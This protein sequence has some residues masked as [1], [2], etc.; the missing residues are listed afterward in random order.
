MFCQVLTGKQPF[1][2]MRPPELAY[3]V[4]SG[5]RPDKPADAEAIGISKSLWELIQKC[6]FGDKTRRPQIQEVVAGVGNAADNWH[7]DMPPSGAEHQED[8]VQ[9]D[10]DEL[11]HGKFLLFSVGPPFLR[12]AVQLGYSRLIRAT[13]Q[14]PT[15]VPALCS[16]VMYTLSWLNKMGRKPPKSAQSPCTNT[17]TRITVHHLV[18]FLHRNA[19][20]SGPS[21]R[22]S[23]GSNRSTEHF[24]RY[25]W[26]GMRATCT[27]CDFPVILSSFWSARS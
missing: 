20:D 17:W 6:W 9:E 13:G 14:L 26:S 19:K 18:G 22:R 3:H 27:L 21:S 12:P 24:R 23:L 16:L 10:S 1:P 8:T 5:L 15:R 11:E 7:T 25:L 4:S 2:N